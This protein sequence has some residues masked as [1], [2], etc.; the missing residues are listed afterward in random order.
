MFDH[1]PPR[2]W[3]SLPGGVRVQGVLL[4]WRR[5]ADGQWMPRVAIEA[6]PGT[7]TK[8]EPEPPAT[9][10]RPGWI[11][12]GLPGGR[13]DLHTASCWMP[14]KGSRPIE[15]AEARA[16]VDAGQAYASCTICNPNP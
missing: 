9:P 4:G 12:Q 14:S 1:L 10:E 5:A 16:M 2:V 6:P 7:V 13:G 11:L 3:V 15:R 8:I